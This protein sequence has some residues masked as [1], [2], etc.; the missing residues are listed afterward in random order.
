MHI[1]KN[2]TI[3]NFYRDRAVIKIKT[4]IRQQCLL[5]WNY[6]V[7]GLDGIEFHGKFAEFLWNT[8]L[9]ELRV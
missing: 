4:R 2:R 9:K 5:I 7:D 1:N 3:C 6:V 8:L